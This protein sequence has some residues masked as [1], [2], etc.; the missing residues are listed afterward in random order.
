MSNASVTAEV[1][2]AWWREE[3]TS[4]KIR[5]CT[6]EGVRERGRRGE[7][8]SQPVEAVPIDVALPFL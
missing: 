4:W 8:N 1:A 3:R 6:Q 5:I 2:G 7:S